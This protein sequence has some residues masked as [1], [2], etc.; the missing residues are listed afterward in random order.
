MINDLE[1]FDN[2]IVGRYRTVERNIKSKSNSFYDSFLDLL[3]NTIKRI[4]NL[5]EVDYDEKFTCGTLLREETIVDFFKSEVGIDDYTYTKCKYYIAK[6]NRHKHFTEHM[7]SIDTVVTYMKV[8]HNLVSTYL[9]YKGREC[10]VFNADY[11]SSIYGLSERENKELKNEVSRL[12]DDLD[13]LVLENKLSAEDNAIYKALVSVQEMENLSLEEQNTELRNQLSKLKDIKINTIEVKLNKALELLY[14][15]TDSVV[16]S[17]AIGIAVGKSIIGQDITQTSYMEDAVKIVKSKETVFDKLD[18]QGKDLSELS[19]K[20]SEMDIDDLYKAAEKAYKEKNFPA[21]MK[22]Y[23]QLCIFKPKD[24]KPPFYVGVCKYYGSYYNEEYYGQ[25]IRNLSHIINTA[26]E[27]IA[28]LDCSG[29]E[30]NEFVKEVMNVAIKDY[31][32]F[33]DNYEDGPY[34]NKY[35]NEFTHYIFDIQSFISSTID[36]MDQFKDLEIYEEFKGKLITQYVRAVK[37]AKGKCKSDLPEDKF[38]T[39]IG[40]NLIPYIPSLDDKAEIPIEEEKT[41]EKK[42]KIRFGHR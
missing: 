38:K 34:V 39:Y 32:Q 1:Y 42:K 30:K 10:S 13:V 36:L 18:R 14:N 16:E 3:E 7:I 21:A 20:F 26:L 12:K 2:S 33:N 5:E 4:L 9:Q 27:S 29:D 19:S 40:D 41:P 15:L 24:W 28:K 23:E 22:Y 17:R 31:E 11:F 37:L 6:V 8:Y 35:M 25:V